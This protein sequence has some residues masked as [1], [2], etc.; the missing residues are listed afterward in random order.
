MCG[1]EAS[2]FAHAAVPLLRITLR[3]MWVYS[4]SKCYVEEKFSQRVSCPG[5]A[6]SSNYGK[7]MKFWILM[8]VR[9]DVVVEI[10]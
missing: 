5:T 2:G 7:N 3:D 10:S 9:W 1:W 4:S 6:T 8:E